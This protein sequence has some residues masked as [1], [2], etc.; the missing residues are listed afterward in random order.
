V[1]T[2]LPRPLEPGLAGLDKFPTDE[3]IL[4]VARTVLIPYS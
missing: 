1:T 2:D 4:A 3:E